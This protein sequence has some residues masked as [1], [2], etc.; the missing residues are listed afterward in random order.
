MKDMK[1]YISDRPT[2]G[3]K[4][5][6]LLLLL[7]LLFCGGA[8]AQRFHCAADTATVAR[9]I[10]QFHEPGANPAEK[11]GVI[12]ETFVGTEYLPVTGKDT[13]GC[14]AVRVDAFDDISFINTVVALARLCTSPGHTRINEYADEL[15]N[16]SCRRGED[17]GFHTKLIYASDWIVD[18]KSRNNIKELTE[19]YSDQF[20][21][22]SLDWVTHHRDQFDALK[23]SA[24]YEDMRMVEMGFRTHKVPHMRRESTEWK[25]VETELNDGDILILLGNDPGM[26]AFE[27]GILRK[28]EDGFHFIHPS[29]KE[30]RVVEEKELIGRYIK[31][32]AKR[33]YGYRWIRLAQ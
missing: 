19:V 26:Y 22:K 24:T 3:G 23:D 9:I 33:T 21:T 17:R 11:A 20:K 29:E 10:A 16:I 14:P 15:E 32:N 27:R 30:G 13:T 4:G 31:R 28:R 25:K 1:Q 2:N 18:N 8:S 5:W 7:L 6:Q 12:A